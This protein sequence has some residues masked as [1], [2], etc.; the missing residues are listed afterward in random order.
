VNGHIMA[1]LAELRRPQLIAEATQYR[2]RKRHRASRRA[3]PPRVRNPLHRPIAV[4]G[5]W[6]AADRL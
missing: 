4:F 2:R 6:L 1:E 3:L 5:A